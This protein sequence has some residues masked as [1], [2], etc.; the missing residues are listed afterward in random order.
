MGSLFSPATK[1]KAFL[2]V[3][4]AYLVLLL[5]FIYLNNSTP[6]LSYKAQTSS[7]RPPISDGLNRTDSSS[8][9]GTGV[10]I[11]PSSNIQCPN[12]RPCEDLTNKCCKPYK[13]SRGFLK[14]PAHDIVL[15]NV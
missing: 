13:T 9:G 1:M 7:K 10:I 5:Y 11:P 6:L 14:C 15:Q 2:N 4:S 8:F 12:S 3:T